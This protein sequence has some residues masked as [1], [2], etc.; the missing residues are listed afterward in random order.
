ML[1]FMPGLLALAALAIPFPA[2]AIDPGVASG[3]IVVGAERL[4]LTHAYAHLRGPE[5]RIA[6]VDREVPQES[7]AGTS[8]LAIETL[9][10]DNKVRGLL[11]RFDPEGRGDIVLRVLDPRTGSPETLGPHSIG[12]SANVLTNFRLGQN[13]VL[14]DLEGTVAAQLRIVRVRFS[15]PL[16]HER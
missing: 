13:R 8:P 1:R 6:V 2:Q 12:R 10:L 15:A 9:A 14:G 4:P 5:I 16:F 3:S 7:I 11:L